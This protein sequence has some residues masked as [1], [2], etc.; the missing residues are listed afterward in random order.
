M[1]YGG[2]FSTTAG[3]MDSTFLPDFADTN[4]AVVGS[5]SKL[6]LICSSARSGSAD[7][8]SILFMTGIS[9]RPW[10]NAR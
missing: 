10:E 7:G 3:N 4:T 6:V 8:R 2:T 5:S 1:N 9:S